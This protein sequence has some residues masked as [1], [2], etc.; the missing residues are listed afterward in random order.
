MPRIKGTPSQEILH[1]LLTAGAFVLAAQSLY[2]WV[3]V[4]ERWFQGKS[5]G[6]REPQVRDAFKY[7]RKKKLIYIEKY[8]HQI[9]I[10]L[11]A[12]GERTAGKYQI[13][14]LS[15]PTPKQWDGAWRLII[16][17][18][19]EKLKVKREAFRGKLRE[20]GFYRLQKSI[21]VF[22]FPCEK[23]VMLLRE[24]FDLQPRHIR[25]LDVQKLEEDEFLR[26]HFN[27]GK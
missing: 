16:F 3:D 10:R 11:T 18:I 26:E 25:A 17:D 23:E 22:P 13:N 20:L 15:I 6:L 8:N 27:L 21:W 5:L 9:Y 1:A 19:P 24:F 12:E 7:L 4:Y 14:K 2:F